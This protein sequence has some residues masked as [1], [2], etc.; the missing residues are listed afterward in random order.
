MAEYVGTVEAGTSVDVSFSVGGRLTSLRVKE[1]QKVGKG[2]L[3][4]SIDNTASTS[5]YQAAK[6]T[7]DQAEDAYRRAKQVYDKGSLPEVKWI[8]VQTQRNQARS[9]CDIAQK[10]LSDCNICAPITGTVAKRFV[11]VGTTV[12]PMQSIVRIIDLRHI[13]VR[14]SVPE[15]DIT[16]ISIGDSVN[17]L[18]N[19]VDSLSLSG[20]I[21]E[22]GVSAD[23]LSHSYLVRIRLI[24]SKTQLSALLPGMV[25]RVQMKGV[26]VNA[27]CGPRF[28]FRILVPSRAVQIDN[29]G[30]RFVWVVSDDSTAVR[31]SVVIGDLTASGVYVTD[32]LSQ[33]DIIVTDGTQK[34]ASGTKVCY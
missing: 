32:G 4:A 9:L 28:S 1:G 26:A 6:V 24:G 13:C 2:Q 5:S 29:D 19:S 33:G 30:S 21:E 22:K 3:I 31:R 20:I 10:N 12:S 15:T 14:M 27:N 34:I 16:G 25:C 17:V 7:L 11:E 23:A 18:I 8:E